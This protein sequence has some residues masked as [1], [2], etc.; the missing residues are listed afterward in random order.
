MTTMT[1]R[2]IQ[3]ENDTASVETSDLGISGIYRGSKTFFSR[4]AAPLRKAGNI[5]QFK[6]ARYTA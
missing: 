6:G 2:G 3:F 1:Y 4:S 5:L